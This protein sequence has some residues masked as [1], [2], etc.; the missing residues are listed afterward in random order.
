MACVVKYTVPKLPQGPVME[1]K[2]KI[3]SVLKK[4]KSSVRNVARSE[5][6]TIKS[7][8]LNKNIKLLKAD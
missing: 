7:L 2:W 4:S 8:K 1:L 6:K 3:R 5:L